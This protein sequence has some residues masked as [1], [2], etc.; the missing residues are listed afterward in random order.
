MCGIAGFSS[1]DKVTADP[2]FTARDRLSHRGP[3]DSGF[4]GDSAQGIGLAHTR[5][6]ILDVSTLGHQAM[7]SPDG[8]IVLVFNGEM[9]NILALYVSH[10][11]FRLSRGR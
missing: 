11:R 4:F 10:V 3:D 7:A 1:G 6:A 9:Y 5:L 8:R 2:L